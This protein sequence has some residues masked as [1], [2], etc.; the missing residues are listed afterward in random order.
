MPFLSTPHR[1]DQQENP[2]EW[3]EQ[4]EE[5]LQE[6]RASV[7]NYIVIGTPLPNYEMVLITDSSTKGGGG[8]L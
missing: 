7:A 8:C 4:E 2:L 5:L 3:E 6:V 1:P